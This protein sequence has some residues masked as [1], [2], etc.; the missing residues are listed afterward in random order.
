[1]VGWLLLPFGIVWQGEEDYAALLP[2]AIHERI[3]YLNR[4]NKILLKLL[5]VVEKTVGLGRKEIRPGILLQLPIL[6]Y[7]W[8]NLYY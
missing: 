2:L 7:I 6:I 3:Y 8:K 5:K 4:Q 1:M